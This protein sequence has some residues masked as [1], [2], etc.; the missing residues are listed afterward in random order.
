M[1]PRKPLRNKRP[2]DAE[3]KKLHDTPEIR[4]LGSALSKKL[5]NRSMSFITISSRVANKRGN[6][7]FVKG[8]VKELG[9]DK[10]VRVAEVVTAL[11]ERRVDVELIEKNFD[12]III[13]SKKKQNV[14]EIVEG[15]QNK[16]KR[17][18]K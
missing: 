4:E 9:V 12:L 18:V 3:L 17:Q 16:F 10:V 8:L 15:L 7:H 6:E 11:V 13:E 5:G 1:Q 14:N 2:T